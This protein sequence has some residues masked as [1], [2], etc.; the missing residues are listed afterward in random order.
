MTTR[1]FVNTSRSYIDP[2]GCFEDDADFAFLRKRILE[3]LAEQFPGA[4]IA[5]VWH[6]RTNAVRDGQSITDEVLES[7][8][9]AID[10]IV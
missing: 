7:V 4:E 1:I 10:S 3:V 9:A 5:E 8:Q 2:E 6:G